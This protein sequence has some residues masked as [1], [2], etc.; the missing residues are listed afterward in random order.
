M[1]RNRTSVLFPDFSRRDLH[2]HQSGLD[3]R[4][5]HQ[6]HQRREADACTNH[7]R[8]KCMPKPVRVRLCHAGGLPVITEQGTQTGGCHAVASGTTFK[9]NEQG[10]ATVARPFQ[11]QVMIEQV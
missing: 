10:R 6:L 3:L 9:T 5:T 1:L 2:V 11:L 4:M 7:V 8:S